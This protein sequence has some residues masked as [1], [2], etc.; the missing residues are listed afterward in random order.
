M[1]QEE[2]LDT[3]GK[4]GLHNEG[5]AQLVGTRNGRSQSLYTNSVVGSKTLLI[6]EGH[7]YKWAT[8]APSAVNRV[9]AFKRLYRWNEAQRQYTSMVG[10]II[11][12]LGDRESNQ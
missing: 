1:R 11:A 5:W 4:R 3:P 10:L 8:Y 2:R 6:P 12:I 9:S 7:L